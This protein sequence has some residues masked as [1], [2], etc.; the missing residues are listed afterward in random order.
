MCVDIKELYLC[1]LLDR[2]EYMR[3]PLS[4]YPEYIIKQYNLREKSLNVY[5]YVEKRLSIYNLPQAGALAKKGLRVNI[6][7][8]GY[9]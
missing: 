9:F 2:L 3:I 8:Y 1:T 5:V 6:A 7:P 4:A